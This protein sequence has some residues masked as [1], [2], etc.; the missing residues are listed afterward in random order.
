[1]WRG[2]GVC[3]ALWDANT[4]KGAETSTR[5]VCAGSGG[6]HLLALPL[7]LHGCRRSRARRSSCWSSQWMTQWQVG[8]WDGKLGGR[9]APGLV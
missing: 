2:W 5:P 4:V 9:V 6:L 8:F 3:L 1:M 7:L